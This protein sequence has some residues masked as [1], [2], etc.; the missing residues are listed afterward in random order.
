MGNRCRTGFQNGL[1]SFFF[2]PPTML[3][4]YSPGVEFLVPFD[5][6]HATKMDAKRPCPPANPVV[7]EWGLAMRAHPPPCITSRYGCMYLRKYMCTSLPS[8]LAPYADGQPAGSEPYGAGIGAGV[9]S[10]P[11]GTQTRLCWAGVLGVQGARGGFRRVAG[12]RR[13]RE[14]AVRIRRAGWS[15]CPDPPRWPSTHLSHGR[16]GGTSKQVGGFR[17]RCCVCR[18]TPS[19]CWV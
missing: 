18:C 2:P 10:S 13:R 19:P 11:A 7:R 16:G 9:P 17:P 1:G 12:T 14:G 3:D 4:M 5:Y 15:A 8:R 6:H